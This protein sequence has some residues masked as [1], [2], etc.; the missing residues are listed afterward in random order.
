MCSSWCS[1]IGRHAVGI[2]GVRKTAVPGTRT[3]D[4]RRAGGDEVAHRGGCRLPR[5]LSAA[6]WRP[7]RPGRHQ[8]EDR[9][10]RRTS[11]NQ[12]PLEDLQ[13]VGAEEAEVERQQ[14]AAARPGGQQRPF[15]ARLHHE[16][17]Q[18]RGDHHRRADRDAVGGGQVARSCGSRAPARWSTISSSQLTAGDVDL[19][20]L[21]GR[22]LHDARR[23]GTGRAGSPAASARRRR[24]SPPARRSRWRPSPA[25]PAG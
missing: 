25:R 12:P 11:G 3:T 17:A 22:G 2:G 1:S 4:L 18:E 24:R 8:H 14:K 5:P 10:R 9:R 16:I 19:A 21:L 6:S 20:A 13:A 7:R 15:P 23:A